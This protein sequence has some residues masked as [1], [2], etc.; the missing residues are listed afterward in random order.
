MNEGAIRE[1]T[2]R[3]QRLR[4]FMKLSPN[5]QVDICYQLETARLVGCSNELVTQGKII[6]EGK[7]N[8]CIV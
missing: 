8:S 3:V 7:Y 6:V 1:I 4:K 5:D 2:N